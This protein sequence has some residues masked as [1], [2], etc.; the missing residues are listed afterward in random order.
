MYQNKRIHRSLMALM[1]L[2]CLC[3]LLTAAGTADLTGQTGSTAQCPYLNDGP[4]QWLSLS[5]LTRPAD[6]LSHL[7]RSF[8]LP[9]SCAAPAAPY[10]LLTELTPDRCQAFDMR[11]YLRSRIP[12]RTNGSNSK[13]DPFFS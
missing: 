3:T 8:H 6:L 13:E 9:Q 7:E 11:H 10:R 1:L 4:V 5:T 12:H 2:L